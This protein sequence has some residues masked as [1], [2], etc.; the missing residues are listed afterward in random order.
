MDYSTKDS[1][2]SWHNFDYYYSDLLMSI[3]WKLIIHLKKQSLKE[4]TLFTS[5]DILLSTEAADLW[6]NLMDGA[7]TKKSPPLNCP[8]SFP[9]KM[10]Q[11]SL[12]SNRALM[13]D[14][15]KKMITC[16]LSLVN[17]LV[18]GHYIKSMGNITQKLK[19]SKSKIPRTP[20]TTCRQL[21]WRVS[22]STA[23]VYYVY[24]LG[25]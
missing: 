23:N 19:L 11:K 1:G 3:R 25:G 14:Q 20:C 9:G 6:I 5:W 16:K 4:M 24:N 7:Q 8:M 10:W 17:Q 18:P 22:S 2:I 13:T 15:K 21:H 12:H